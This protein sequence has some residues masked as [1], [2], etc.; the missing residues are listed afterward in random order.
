[1]DLDQ[2]LMSIAKTQPTSIEPFIF[3]IG[4]KP[5]NEIISALG[6]VVPPNQ[7]KRAYILNNVAR[8]SEDLHPSRRHHGS[9]TGTSSQSD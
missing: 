1:M 4:K 8:V 5:D 7:N 2:A 6:M 9:D 3:A